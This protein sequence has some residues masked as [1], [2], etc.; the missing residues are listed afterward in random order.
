[1]AL[2]LLLALVALAVSQVPL[3]G[4]LRLPLLGVLVALLY[5]LLPVAWLSQKIVFR[6]LDLL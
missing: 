4:L 2:G 6:V 1:M 5:A 3:N